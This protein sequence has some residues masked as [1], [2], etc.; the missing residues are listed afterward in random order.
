MYS[1]RYVDKS[2]EMT[3]SKRYALREAA[4]RISRVIPEATLIERRN[5][6]V[7]SIPEKTFFEFPEV[8]LRPD[9]VAVLTE[10]ARILHDRKSIGLEVMAHYHSDG[11]ASHAM[12]ESGR[13]AVAI[14]AALLSRKVPERRVLASGLGEA[15]PTD[16][17]TTIQGRERN[18][19]IDFVIRNEF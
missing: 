19:R 9:A 15:W 8:S 4:T 3:Y 10:V 7:I 11:R 1:S 14:Q 16:A 13:R 18:R 12:V 17:N 2:P 6:A 5:H